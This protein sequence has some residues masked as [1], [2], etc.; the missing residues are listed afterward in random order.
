MTKLGVNIDHIATLREARGITE[1]S[2]V[3]GAVL[4]EQAGCHGITAH[5]REDRRHIKKYDIFAIQQKIKIP[6][7]MEMSINPEIVKIALELKPAKACLVPENRQEVTTEGGLAVREN[8]KAIKKTVS[9]LSRAGIN[10][11]LFIDPA[12]E[13]ITAAAETGAKVIE[14]HTGSYADAEPGIKR[15]EKL[16]LIKEGA[17]LASSLELTVNAGHGLNYSNT[18]ALVNCFAFNELNIGHALIGYAV[19][20]GLDRAVKDMLAIVNS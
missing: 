12:K 11:S 13:E 18:Q 7:N 8:F 1:P 20:V 6:L 16:S 14:L 3:A 5:L 17:E 4:A 15:Q 2:P 10:V 9:R 19:F